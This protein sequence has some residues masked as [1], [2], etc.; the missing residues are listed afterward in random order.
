[1]TRGGAIGK[2]A[3]SV[4]SSRCTPGDAPPPRLRGLHHVT[5]ICA[6]APT[7]VRFYRDL[8]GL[9]LVKRTVDFEAPDVHHLYF[10]DERGSPG[11]LLT[12]FEFRNAGRGHA[13]AGTAHLVR[14]RVASPDALG[15]W[16]ERLARAGVDLAAGSA[17]GALGLRD[18]DGLA[19]ELVVLGEE[20]GPPLRASA[21]GVPAELALCGLAGVRA[22]GAAPQRLPEVL[23]LPEAQLALDPAP[24][25]PSELGAGTV[26][27]V[28]FAVA[29]EAEQLAWRERLVAAGA[30]PTPVR[31]RRWFRSVY[32]RE[33]G[34]VLLELA[35]EGP[36]FT[37]DEDLGHLGEALRLPEHLEGLRARLERSLTPLPAPRPVA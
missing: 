33:P 5:A 23:G 26:H 7:S 34:G 27:H 25:A 6:D 16:A 35:T 37:L 29:D 19:L 15:F 2:A 17:P 31:D 32:V 21:P 12:L 9:R 10:G 1:V 18:P 22:Y 36:G 14:V 3:G 28:A 4:S 11:S 30:G 24:L 13:G 20:H 8:L